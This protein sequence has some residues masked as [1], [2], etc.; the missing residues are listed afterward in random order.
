[1]WTLAAVACVAA[2]GNPHGATAQ[3]YPVNG[4][5]P[6]SDV[7]WPFNPVPP[8]GTP[9]LTWNG[10]IL[11]YRKFDISEGVPQR[12]EI[13][14]QRDGER[15]PTTVYVS[16]PLQVDGKMWI[17][18]NSS[19]DPYTRK[20]RVCDDLPKSIVMGQTHV[21]IDVWFVRSTIDFSQTVPATNDIKV[22]DNS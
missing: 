2:A 16:M 10:T 20:Y 4:K 17:C 13:K 14:F 19:P 18:P 12:T 22:S 7:V 8:T 21:K 9:T 5:T 6:A 11:S 3:V 15:S 1:M